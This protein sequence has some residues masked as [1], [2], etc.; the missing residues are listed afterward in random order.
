M[1]SKDN[2]LDRISQQG[3]DRMMWLEEK[4]KNRGKRKG[5]EKAEFS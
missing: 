2:N 4:D 5:P 3:Q 1:R